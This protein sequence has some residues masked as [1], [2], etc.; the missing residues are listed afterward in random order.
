MRIRLSF[1]ILAI[2]MKIGHGVVEQKKLWPI[3]RMKIKPQVINITIDGK[4]LFFWPK[5]DW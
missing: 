4:I 3:P 2:D 5:V 1:V